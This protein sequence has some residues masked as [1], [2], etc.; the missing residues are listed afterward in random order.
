M[1]GIVHPALDTGDA[2]SCEH[3][4]HAIDRIHQLQHLMPELFST[5][6]TGAGAP[7]AARV[8]DATGAPPPRGAGAAAAAAQDMAPAGGGAAQ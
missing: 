2:I 5:R 1:A 7:P 6:G 3:A 4:D 8:E